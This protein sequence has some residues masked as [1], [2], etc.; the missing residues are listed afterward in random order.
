[1]HDGFL[2]F[3]L[4]L[5][6]LLS[7]PRLLGL[8]QQHVVDGQLRDAAQQRLLAASHALLRPLDLLREELVRGVEQKQRDGPAKRATQQGAESKRLRSEEQI[9]VQIFEER[10]VLRA[11][12]VLRH[13]SLHQQLQKHPKVR[14][15]RLP[16]SPSLSPK[17]YLDD[18][19]TH[20]RLLKTGVLDRSAFPFS[21]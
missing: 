7:L 10:N 18:L 1:M 3:L 9:G 5:L 14:Q 11:L 6:V 21:R 13:N 2:A 17:R 8:R 19:L 15:R 16:L 20:R 4:V 12:L